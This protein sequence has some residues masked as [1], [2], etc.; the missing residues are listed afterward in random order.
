MRQELGDQYE[1]EEEEEEEE[2][3]EE[4]EEEGE[5]GEEGEEEKEEKP[6]G[7]ST[8]LIVFHNHSDDSQFWISMGGYDCGYLYKCSLNGVDDN[9]NCPYEPP[10]SVLIPSVSSGEIPLHAVKFK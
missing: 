8:L 6:T 9:N 4:E 1:S 3:H 2:E 7:P 5:G 10:H